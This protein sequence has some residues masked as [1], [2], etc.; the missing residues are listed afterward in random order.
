MADIKVVIQLQDTTEDEINSLGSSAEVSNASI[1]N[2]NGTFNRLSTKGNGANL[3]SWATGSLSLAD[4]YV[5]G[6]NTKL[7]SQYGYNGYVF[8]AVPESKQLAVTIEIVGSN[9]DSI[10]IY[11]DKVANQYP[12]KAYRDGNTNDIIYSD[13]AVWAIKFSE[14]AN[15]HTITFLEWNRANYNACITYVGEL[16][17]KLVIDRTSLK[18]LDSLSQSTGQPKDIFYGVTPSSGNVSLIDVDGEIKDYVQ[19]GIIDISNTHIDIYCN[20]DNEKLISHISSDGEYLE[21]NKTLSLSLEDDFGLLLNNKYLG[22]KL[23]PET[24]AY[25]IIS[26]LLTDMGYSDYIDFMLGENIIVSHN[27]TTQVMSVKNYL[28][29]IT[30]PYPHLNESTYREALDKFCVLAQLNMSKKD[31]YE[32]PVFT[33]ARPL[34]MSNENIINIDK[35][36]MFGDL[37]TDVIVKNKVKSVDC[38]YRTIVYDF[39]EIANNTIQ[40]FDT[41]SGVS[42]SYSELSGKRV[43]NNSDNNS[44]FVVLKE[45]VQD[46]YSYN[47]SSLNKYYYSIIKISSNNK[48]NI[49]LDYA[50]FKLS[51]NSH[52]LNPNSDPI[53]STTQQW[54]EYTNEQYPDVDIKDHTKSDAEIVNSWLHPNYGTY[55]GDNL[56]MQ[57]RINKDGTLDFFVAF[58]ETIQLSSSSNT[59]VRLIDNYSFSFAV[60]K[61]T[62]S[63]INTSDNADIEITSNELLQGGTLFNGSMVADIIKNNILNDYANG[64]RTGTLTVS[65]S[66]YYY[67]DGSLAKD[68]A[69]GQIIDVGDF[70][71]IKGNTTIWRVTGR[72]FRKIGVPMIDLELQEVRVVG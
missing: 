29:Q 64:I 35:R 6:A 25:A 1:Q 32:V 30:I 9:I 47:D 14:P 3:K 55:S 36:N 2:V 42:N 8:G 70:V 69:S 10:V 15:S 63:T 17:N 57:V 5:G 67:L 72:N 28:S 71:Q 50:R 22:K 60:K 13:D 4:G 49:E 33:S 54:I 45:R 38:E 27:N 58:L 65:C 41:S 59:V 40:I 43:L 56:E 68:W 11:G 48:I 23:S 62:Y 52:I 20:N 21:A 7:V 46:T 12:T 31:G 34:V 66:N 19:D 61:I 39:N 37:K 26:S 51:A 18:S 16:K 44:G 53:Y 24:S